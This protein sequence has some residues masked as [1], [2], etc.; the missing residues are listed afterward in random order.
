[1]TKK[2]HF[3]HLEQMTY[4]FDITFYKEKKKNTLDKTYVLYRDFGFLICNNF[5]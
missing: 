2:T 5:S 4:I 3:I 1:M